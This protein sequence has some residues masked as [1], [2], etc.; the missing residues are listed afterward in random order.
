MA[1]ALRVERGTKAKMYA[2]ITT[3][4]TETYNGFK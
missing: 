2:D 4:L 1:T 3:R